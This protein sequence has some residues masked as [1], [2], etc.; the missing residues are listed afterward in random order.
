VAFLV[1]IAEIS[2][3]ITLEI[4]VVIIVIHRT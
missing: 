3:L 4:V 2:T 1:V